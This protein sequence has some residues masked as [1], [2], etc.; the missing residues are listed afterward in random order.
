MMTS[1]Y[2]KLGALGVILCALLG[3][4]LWGHH[5]GAASVQAKWEAMKVVQAHAVAKAEAQAKATADATAKKFNALSDQYE[6]AIHAQAPSVAD[7]AASGVAGGT[8]RLRDAA[9]CPGTGTVSATVSA[10]RAADAAATQAL[11]DRVQAAVAAVRA[12]D[13]ADRRENRLDVQVRALQAVLRAER[14]PLTQ[15][16]ENSGRK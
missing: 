2:L 11:A 16:P 1:I 15:M 13:E 14:D 10:S 4:Y 5:N 7:S 6:A 12:G 3:L 8:L 9:T